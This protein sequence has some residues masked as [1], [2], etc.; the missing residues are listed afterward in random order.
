MYLSG[1]ISKYKKE[2]NEAVEHNNRSISSG[3]A[4]D[5]ADYRYMAGR[6]AGLKEAL[7]LF[8]E[9]T[10]QYNESDDE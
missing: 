3:C 10:K 2:L 5:Y 7:V 6:T 9:I 1:L 4:K 8:E